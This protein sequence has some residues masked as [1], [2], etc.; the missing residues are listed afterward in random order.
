ML[1]STF[2]HRFNPHLSSIRSKTGTTASLQ[3]DS[4]RIVNPEVRRV[5]FDSPTPTPW[6]YVKSQAKNGATC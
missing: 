3:F 2:W 4:P 6:S 1:W 5:V